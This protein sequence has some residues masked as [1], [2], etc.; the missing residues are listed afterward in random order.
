VD[1]HFLSRT[2]RPLLRRR[3]LAFARLITVA[4]VVASVAAVTAL[5]SATLWRPLPYPDADRLVQIYRVPEDRPGIANATPLFPVEFVHLDARGPS[6]E[7]IAGIWVSDRAIGGLGE[8]DSVT[9]GRVSA[10]FFSMLGASF[11]SGRPFTDSEIQQDAALVVVSHR[12]WTRMFGSD[13]DLVG[14]AIQIDRRAHTVIGITAPAFEPIFTRS[15]FWT[16]LRFGDVTTLRASVAQTI[17]RLRD[18]ASEASA[19][20][21]L[22]PVTAAAFQH[23]PDLIR[24]SS[25]AATGLREFRFGPQR[26]AIVMLALIVSFLILLAMANLANL[27][28]ADLTSR[29]QDFSL[30]SALGGSASA[31]VLAELAPGLVLA[32]AGTAAGLWLAA[33]AVPWVL[34]LNPSLGAAGVAVSIDWRVALMSGAAAILVMLMAVMVPSWRMARRHRLG[35][36]DAAR[37]AG[38]RGGRVRALLVGA[39]TAIALV[40][41]SASML[42]LTTLRR[43]ASIDPG[44][45]ASNVV[46]GQ[47]RLSEN[48]FPDHVA[49]VQFVRTV[50]ERLRQTPGVVAAGTTLNL[51]TVGGTFTT[52]LSVEDAPRPD[53]S[54][55]TTPFRRVSPGYF[56]T[57]RIRLLR[58]RTFE[59]GDDD[60]KTPV[61][62]VNESFAQ[63]YWP[64]GEALGRR[65]KRGLATSP[66]AEIVGVVADTRDAG[67]TQDTGPV[68]YTCYY[69]NTAS[70]T[71]AGLVVRTA[72][73]P[74]GAIRH[75][76]DVIWSVDPAQPLSGVVV[77]N[78]FLA[79]SLGPQQFRSWLVGLCTICGIVLAVIGIYGVT[80]RSV[81]ERTRE[82]GIRIALGGHPARVWWR[83]AILSLRAV[84]VGAA[85]GI[86]LSVAVD[87][88]MV[89]LLPELIGTHWAFRLGAALAITAAGAAAAIV[90][91]RH[92][93]RIEPVIA[94]RSE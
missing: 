91:A 49:R 87:A 76:K 21:D 47:L 45:D 48:A 75:I 5:A 60:P 62:I 12:L 52:N 73:D 69:Q 72:G 23:I 84:A 38:G 61:A 74:A 83:L 42:L 46:T 16:P 9:G 58:G 66:W 90:A 68:L 86:A 15:E 88:G 92:A 8:P 4:I 81:A 89:Q 3:G 27:S 25:M 20:Q 34:A 28:L 63:R 44:F 65:V 79:S 80:S 22:A 57:M 82:V 32:G 94:L 1:L 35:T 77:L 56:E 53:G 67:L 70:A 31:I 10:A 24:G 6:I 2:F 29:A 39:Q 55:Y 36:V 50:L 85:G 37:V 33:T 43:N 11:M 78:D 93:A 14:K 30:R 51:F 40:L 18:G 17:G 26:S 71:P 7:T 59:D 13:P 64:D 19:T 41:L 54:A